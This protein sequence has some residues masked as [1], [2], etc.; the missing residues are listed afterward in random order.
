MNKTKSQ[1]YLRFRER[2]GIH[3]RVDLQLKSNF[4]LVSV[5]AESLYQ[6][7]NPA[8]RLIG[9]VSYITIASLINS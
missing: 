8:D 7:R 4:K 1:G 9:R 5:I 2:N 3:Y 6:I